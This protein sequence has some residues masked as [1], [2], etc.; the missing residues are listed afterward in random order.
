MPKGNFQISTLEFQFKI[1][2]TTDSP[3]SESVVFLYIKPN[4]KI[5]L[6][7]FIEIFQYHIFFV[8]LHLNRHTIKSS[9]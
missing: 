5:I 7:Q 8:T 1:N 2:Q 3:T 9:Y 4:L 6:L